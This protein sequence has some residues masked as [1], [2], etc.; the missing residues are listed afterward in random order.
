MMMIR[1]LLHDKRCDDDEYEPQQCPTLRQQSSGDPGSRRIYF[2]RATVSICVPPLKALPRASRVQPGHTFPRCTLNTRRGQRT[3]RVSCPC[4]RATAASI[5]SLAIIQL[6]SSRSTNALHYHYCC[7]RP[8]PASLPQH[9]GSGGRTASSVRR[10]RHQPARSG[11]AK[12]LL[13]L[14]VAHMPRSHAPPPYSLRSY[15]TLL[16][17]SRETREPRVET[18][19]LRRLCA[20]G[21][22]LSRSRQTCH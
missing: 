17:A 8:P 19:A 4:S 5:N 2:S 22:L 1:E 11:A 10:L 20:R 16:D 6:V 18:D 7:S 15:E 12:P 3:F 13:P 21:E 14:P 9:V